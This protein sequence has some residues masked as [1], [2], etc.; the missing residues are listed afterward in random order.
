MIAMIFSLH[1]FAVTLINGQVD[2]F[3]LDTTDKILTPRPISEWQ[4]HG[5]LEFRDQF[6]TFSCVYVCVEEGAWQRRS[7][8]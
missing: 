5:L 1:T 4:S 2:R 7:A 8:G 3:T 6:G